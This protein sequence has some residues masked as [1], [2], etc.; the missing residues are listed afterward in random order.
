MTDKICPGLPAEKRNYALKKAK[1]DLIAFIDSDAYPRADWLDSVILV[2]GNTVGVCGPGI[3]PFDAPFCEKAADLVFK[4]LPFS[5][6]VTPKKRRFVTDYPTFNLIVRKDIIDR[7]GGFQHFL[8]GEDTLFCQAVS[9]Y[10]DILYHPEIVV[11]HN[12]RP[13]FIPY[14]KQ[15]ATWAWHRGFLISFALAGW[16]GTWFVYPFN[17][18]RGLFRHRWLKERMKDYD[19][20]LE[21]KK[22]EK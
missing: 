3:I 13:L 7:V 15:I 21:S 8:T 22:E 11:Y 1:G 10:G 14:F 6:R 20:E 4:L 2:H 9:Q 17:F 19:K 16:V 18:M 12:R 5:Y